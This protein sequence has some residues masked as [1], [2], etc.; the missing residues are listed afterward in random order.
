[1]TTKSLERQLKKLQETAKEEERTAE[2]KRKI[3]ALKY[4]KVIKAREKIR[5]KAATLGYGIKN[6][7]KK[8]KEM[9]E[10]KASKT[11]KKIPQEDYLTRL[12][13]ALT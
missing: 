6:L 5:E 8:M 9:E 1:M 3:K 4:R 13:K 10:K 2:L 12:N 11:K 7:S